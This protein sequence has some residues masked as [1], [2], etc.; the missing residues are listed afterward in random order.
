MRAAAVRILR[1]LHAA[2]G[3]WL[4]VVDPPSAVFKGNTKL[5][6]RTRKSKRGNQPAVKEHCSSFG[7]VSDRKGRSYF[8]CDP[9][10]LRAALPR[11]QEAEESE[12]WYRAHFRIN[13]Q[14]VRR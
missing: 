7:P 13:G 3:R 12:A 6:A 10:T 11:D 5:R 2:L 8:D 4:S 9:E 1:A 14:Q